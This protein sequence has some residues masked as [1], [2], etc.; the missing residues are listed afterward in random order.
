MTTLKKICLR[1]L[2]QQREVFRS[3]INYVNINKSE[4]KEFLGKNDR[5][6][7]LRELRTLWNKPNKIV[8]DYFVMNEHYECFYDISDEEFK[9]LWMLYIDL[10]MRVQTKLLV[11]SNS[12]CQDPN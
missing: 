11:M 6:L 8:E 3:I 10:G 9:I 12:D 4:L 5:F 7:H 1:E 2:K